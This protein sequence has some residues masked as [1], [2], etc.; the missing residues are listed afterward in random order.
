MPDS[1]EILEPVA[2][3]VDDGR[4]QWHVQLKEE[5]EEEAGEEEKEEE[6]GMRKKRKSR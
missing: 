4:V 1:E 3:P 6:G 2:K 5:L